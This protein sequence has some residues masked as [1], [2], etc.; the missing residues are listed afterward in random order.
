[1]GDIHGAV[2]L[3]DELG[4]LLDLLKHVEEHLLV[5]R[6]FLFVVQVVTRAP[7]QL[8]EEVALAQLLVLKVRSSHIRTLSA[9]SIR[10]YRYD[11]LCELALEGLD[12]FELEV[13]DVVTL[14]FFLRVLVLC[15]ELVEYEEMYL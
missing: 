14:S 1:M 6:V 12:H 3:L 15:E 8:I 11:A 9:S 10:S 4:L 13:V 7:F 5:V 2:F